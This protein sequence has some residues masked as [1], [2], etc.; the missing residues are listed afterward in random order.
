MFVVKKLQAVIPVNA[1]SLE[2]ASYE[3]TPSSGM[4]TDAAIMHC[5]AVTS[6]A[7][8]HIAASSLHAGEHNGFSRAF[9][10]LIGRSLHGAIQVHRAWFDNCQG[11]PPKCLAQP[12]KMESPVPSSCSLLDLSLQAGLQI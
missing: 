8:V 2:S 7:G 9:D 11:T 6:Y 5:E 3:Y 4:K 12:G 1:V 10:K